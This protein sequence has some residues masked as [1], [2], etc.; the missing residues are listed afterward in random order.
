[1]TSSCLKRTSI[2]QGLSQKLELV[3][4]LHVSWRSRRRC[5]RRRSLDAS[6]PR[7]N[8]ERQVQVNSQSTWRVL[9]GHTRDSAHTNSPSLT[10]EVRSTGL[11]SLAA[12]GHRFVQTTRT[13][14]LANDSPGTPQTTESVH[15]TLVGNKRFPLVLL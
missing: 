12:P 1:M 5:Q 7:R 9:L 6:Q 11:P 14:L 13:I 2:L 4:W 15:H 8:T 10:F 3:S